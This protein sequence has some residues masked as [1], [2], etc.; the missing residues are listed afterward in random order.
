M[1]M[2]RYTANVADDCTKITHSLKGIFFAEV[3]RITHSCVRCSGSAIPSV[4]G[5]VATSALTLTYWNI[6]DSVSVPICGCS[7]CYKGVALGLPLALTYRIIIAIKPQPEPKNSN[8]ALDVC[9]T[10]A[11]FM[12][13]TN[14]VS[15][16]YQM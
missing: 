4:I 3:F 12:L 7:C 10:W 1:F 9:C 6:F 5:P 14:L 13:R 8:T 2:K 15:F 11:M 16:K